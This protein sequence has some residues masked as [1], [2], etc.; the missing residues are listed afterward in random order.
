MAEWGILSAMDEATLKRRL[1][2]GE[3]SR[4]ELKSVVMRNYQVDRKVIAR[5]IVAMANS[6]GGEL[7]LGVEDDGLPTGIGT[8][9]NADALM[10]QVSQICHEAVQPTLSCRLLKVEADDVQV[11]V[12]EVPGHAPERPYATGGHYYVRDANRTREA[13]RAELVRLLQSEDH[14][15]DEQPVDDATLD[16]FDLERVDQALKAAYDATTETQRR[17]YLRAMKCLGPDERPTV[18]GVLLFAR[19]PQRFLLDARISGARV[20]GTEPRLD[21]ADLQ[22]M[23]GP[24]SEQLEA[25]RVFLGRHLS[26]SARVEGWDRVEDPVVPDGVLREAVLNAVVHRDYRTASQVRIFVYDDRV[27]VIN[28]GVLLNRLDVDSLRLGGVSQ[29]R[30]PVIASLMARLG[31]RENLGFG[32]PEMFRLMR[33][34]GR[35]E[36]EIDVGAGQFRLILRFG[37]VAS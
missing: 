24:L 37:D 25:A 21:L 18:A 31:R 32:I 26:R 23:N 7:F 35:P 11:L 10:R 15:Y 8:G 16:D 6:G 30:N 12:V 27:E 2:L 36:P 17:P 19:E 13:S 20:P 34:E 5:S 4:T 3:D 9:E 1:R 28:P 22:E 14:H 29:K 33:D